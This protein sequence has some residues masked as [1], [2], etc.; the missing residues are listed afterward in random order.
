MPRDQRLTSPDEYLGSKAS[1]AGRKFYRDKKVDYGEAFKTRPEEPPFTI[2]RFDSSDLRR[3]LTSKKPVLNPRLNFIGGD[4]QQFELFTGLPR[5]DS[6]KG[7]LYNFEEG[8]P[9]TRALFTQYPEFKEIWVELY[10]VSPTL[11]KKARNP[12]PSS[13][14]PDPMGRILARA[15]NAA[16]REM[17]Q[18]YSVAQLLQGEGAQ[19]VK[20]GEEVEKDKNA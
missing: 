9:N 19:E 7:D 11:E 18:D 1:Q 2:N 6:S 20:R 3:R 12:M 13:R 8:R 4:P 16:E 10:N 5:F 14:N 17:E 15:E